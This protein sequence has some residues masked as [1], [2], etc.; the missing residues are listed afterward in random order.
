ME[1]LKSYAK[2]LEKMNGTTDNMGMPS[3][4][5]Q[6]LAQKV[7]QNEQTGILQKVAGFLNKINPFDNLFPDNRVE[8]PVSG[9]KVN[10]D[11]L[12]L[13]QNRPDL[14]EKFDRTGSI[15]SDM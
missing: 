1:F 11:F 9:Q 8:D 15:Y 14:R 2:E 6:E 7:N 10:P 13:L 3:Q 12:K 4:G 5:A